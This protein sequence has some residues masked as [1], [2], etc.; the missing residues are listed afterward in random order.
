MFDHYLTLFDQYL[1]LFDHYLTLFD[2]YLTLFDRDASGCRVKSPLL[3]N[4]WRAY[5]SKQSAL[6]FTGQISV[7]CPGGQSDDSNTNLTT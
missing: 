6:L 5:W 7:F 2:H 1:T 4:R 3:A